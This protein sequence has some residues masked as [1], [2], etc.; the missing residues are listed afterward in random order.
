MDRRIKIIFGLFCIWFII[1]ACRLWDMQVLHATRY[2]KMSLEN[3]SRL[4]RL[5]SA[6]GKIY[7]R[8]GKIVADNKAA[9][10]LVVM[11]DEIGDA[12]TLAEDVSNLTKLS[13][14]YILKKIKENLFKP[15]VPAV[16]ASDMSD[17]T[18]VKVAESK[19]RLPGITIQVAPIR[20][21][22]LGEVAAH[23][24]GYVGEAGKNELNSGY[25]WGDIVGRIGIEKEWDRELRGK[26]GY[27]EV[28]V[29]Y[30][31]N[32][33]TVLK[34]IEPE[35]GGNIY[36]TIDSVLQE[37]L[38]NAMK[39]HHGAGVVMNSGA[40]E[41]LAL[42]SAP[43]FDPNL[44]VSPVKEEVI[45]N[46]FGDKNRPMVNRAVGGLYPPGSVFKII[47]ALAA[48]EKGTITKKSI[49]FCDGEFQLGNAIFKC[50]E[51][52]GHGWIDLTNALKKSC[53][54]YFY[55][56]GLKVGPDAIVDVAGRFGLGRCTGIKMQGE[57][58]GLLPK[59]DIEQSKWFSGD[60]VNLSIGH[61][62]ILVT[63][64]Q[65]ACLISAVANG[66]ILYKPLLALG[67]NKETVQINI[68]KGYLNI[69]KEGLFKVVNDPD[70]TG[71]KA[72]VSGLDIAGK[73][74][75]VEIKDG[76]RKRDI[77]W[78]AGFGPFDNPQVAVVIVL[79]EGES[80][81]TTAA[82]IAKKVFQKWQEIQKRFMVNSL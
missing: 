56:V 45:I 14:E 68:D 57:K 39:G 18:L 8:N 27:R 19:Y 46:L 63:P 82:P 24:V 60:T 61:G 20:D 62:K 44:L 59:N 30:R 75:T 52:K 13:P 34:V 32:I 22:I 67:E 54:E 11:I 17:E 7:D 23:L 33:D 70:G 16:L 15:F 35:I 49:F 6:R 77:C 81:G 42:V 40:G 80:G 10:E 21:Y 4:V 36:L 74:G 43:G 28:Q 12:K 48:L 51:K 25:S 26:D 55:Q 2:T 3:R 53:N 41:I 78:F 1:I 37:E 47:I 72:Y 73:T 79:E 64:I 9:T 29:D 66:G 38:Y 50:W 31:G 58:S 76:R 65:I 71:H 5:P 69:V